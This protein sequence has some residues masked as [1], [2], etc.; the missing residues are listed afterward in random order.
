MSAVNRNVKDMKMPYFGYPDR[1]DG[2]VTAK[3]IDQDGKEHKKIIGYLTVSDPGQERMIPNQYFKNTYQDLYKE[4]YPNEKIPFHEM[5]VGLYAL[6][7]GIC[8]TNGLYEVLKDIYGPVSANSILDYAMF[9]ILHKSSSTQLFENAMVREVLFCDNLHTD[10]WYY[11]FFSKK[12]NEDLHHQLRI[13][14]IQ[15][16]K[17]MGLKK[18]WLSIDGSNNDCEARNSFLTKYGFGKSHN[19][20]KTIV[21]YMYAVDAETGQ[22]VTYFVYEGNVPDSKAFQTMSTFLASF[23]IEIEGV[24]LDRGFA[25]ENVFEAIEKNHWKYVIMLPS[26]THAHTQMIDNHGE[27]IR[28]KSKYLL[29]DDAL[30]GVSDVTRL[31]STHD[32]VSKVCLFFNGSEGSIQSSRLIKKIQTEKK[33]LKKAIKD[34]RRASV[35]KSLKKYLDIEGTGSERQ[36]V[37]HYDNWDATMSSKGYHTIAVSNEIDSTQ[38]HR[39]YKMRDTSETQYSILKSQ[40]GGDTTRVHNTE[41]IYSKFAILFIASLIRHEIEIA[42]KTLELDT[43]PTIQN[44]EQVTLLYTAQERYEAVRNLNSQLKN[45]FAKFGTSQ[46][47]IERLARSFNDRN[48][49]DSKNPDRALPDRETPVILTNSRKRGR[50]SKNELMVEGSATSIGV[51]SQSNPKSKGGRPIGKRDSKP[52]KPRSD[53]GKKRGKRQ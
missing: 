38:A 20:N 49:K 1:H 28:W 42:C 15:H 17:A 39:L 11:D 27:E 40:E 47:D 34:G 3:V 30:F 36:V 21:G 41:G 53:K 48:R 25:V 32:R 4:A 46:D 18:V 13:R 12:L 9:S 16:L 2:R 43:N 29:D 23:D 44:L 10:N 14:W 50:K 22:P 7:L 37:T 19:K 24:I 45:L 33:R 5:R 6:T 51:P 8:S 26:D 31:F 52:R 35:D